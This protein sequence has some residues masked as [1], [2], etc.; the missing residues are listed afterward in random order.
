MMSENLIDLAKMDPSGKKLANAI[1]S[2]GDVEKEYDSTIFDTLNWDVMR[3]VFATSQFSTCAPLI[4][5]QKV[6]FQKLKSE[7]YGNSEE[8]DGTLRIYNSL[9]EVVNLSRASKFELEKVNS[10]T[11]TWRETTSTLR[12]EE[13]E[14][15]RTIYWVNDWS[16]EHQS[17]PETEVVRRW[18]EY[19]TVI[20]RVEELNRFKELAVDE[21]NRRPPGKDYC[22]GIMDLPF[23]GMSFEE[24]KQ[25]LREPIV[26]SDYCP[27]SA[28]LNLLSCGKG[29]WKMVLKFVS[30]GEHD[31]DYFDHEEFSK[32][33]R[34]LGLPYYQF[35]I[36][37]P[38]ENG[39]QKVNGLSLS[40]LREIHTLKKKGNNKDIYLSTSQC[41]RCERIL[42]FCTNC[43]PNCRKCTEKMWWLLLLAILITF[44]PILLFYIIDDSPDSSEEWASD[45]NAAKAACVITFLPA[46]IPLKF[47]FECAWDRWFSKNRHKKAPF[48]DQHL[49]EL[50]RRNNDFKSAAT[51]KGSKN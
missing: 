43:C 8:V 49:S 44:S 45:L 51:E 4:A 23:K 42:E 39:E 22:Y 36:L 32:W 30:G 48:I 6:I 26:K 13:R 10:D 33:M 50:K 11:V 35:E 47:F 28:S 15:G 41:R 19:E 3:E 20:S 1:L 21:I 7:I 34:K 16:G 5:I 2:L 27:V 17:A 24:A 12:E 38:F 9:A 46:L 18:T 14:T 37:G 40:D 31:P 25:I 29:N